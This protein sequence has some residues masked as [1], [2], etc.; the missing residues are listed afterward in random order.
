MCGSHVHIISY[1]ERQAWLS[2]RIRL[3]NFLVILK[4]FRRSQP[5]FTYCHYG[6]SLSSHIFGALGVKHSLG[7]QLLYLKNSAYAVRRKES[8]KNAQEKQTKLSFSGPRDLWFLEAKTFQQRPL[9]LKFSEHNPLF[10][11]AFVGWRT[12]RCPR[13]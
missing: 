8:G 13:M 10:N 3:F 7:A 11:S 1:L 2:P 4:H 6:W 12:G 9:S 5:R